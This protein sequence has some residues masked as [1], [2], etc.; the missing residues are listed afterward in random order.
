MGA[1]AHGL[2]GGAHGSMGTWAHGR[3]GKVISL[4]AHALMLPCASIA[5]TLVCCW[6]SR[7]SAASDCLPFTPRNSDGNYI[8]PGVQG[9][10]VYR[11]VDGRELVLDAFVQ[12]GEARRPLVVIVHG[13]RWSSGSR[14]GSVGQFLELLTSAGFNWVS[15]D[16]R[17]GP[18]DRYLEAVDD[19]EAAV[20]FVQC[21]ATALHA[22]PSRL[23]LL[24]EEAGAH[25]VALAAAQRPA[26][27][28]ATVL[29]G[30]AYDLRELASY[31]GA[32]D[33]VLRM[34]ASPVL[35]AR[36]PIGP[37]LAIH[38]SG[39]TD[40]SASQAAAYCASVAANGGSCERLVVAGASHRAENWWPRHW[41]YKRRLVEWLIARVGD[42]GPHEPYRTAL[43]K[44]I[45]FDREERLTL[46]LWTPEGPGPFPLV[47][48]AHGGGWEAGDRVTYVPPLFEPLARAG[49]AWCSIDYRLT[50]QVQNPVQLR[51]VRTA[52]G[53]IRA[54]A[55]EWRIDADR[56]ALVGESASGQMVAQ[57]ATEDRGLAGVVS[58]YGVYDL[59][60]MVSDAS[61]RSLLVRLFGRTTLD[62]EARALMRRYSPLYNVRRRMPPMLLVHG[63]NERLWDQGVAMAGALKRVGVPSELLRLD[64]APHG[65][66]N[67]EGRPEW[68]HY[69]ARVI[70]WLRERFA[71]AP[72]ER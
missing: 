23:V 64:G 67:W 12:R 72:A 19:V 66:G 61:P 5:V 25:L 60:A 47:V 36:A 37:V 1:W 33:P 3:M 39:D 51:D 69:K 50:P 6:P 16:Y 15:I 29:V 20:E 22:D 13:G 4:C 17:L 54:R 43:R 53:F 35:A 70:S 11:R 46:D 58:F 45:V 10:I 31:T 48:I 26:G 40:V 56:I 59:E 44:G 30:G 9:A 65:M 62:A 27:L 49:F 38:G 63:T 52:L 71:T 28:S 21:H 7:A 55:R 57:I 32:T 68:A 14:V 24:G 2:M 42:P 34:Q 18:L 41:G 8:V